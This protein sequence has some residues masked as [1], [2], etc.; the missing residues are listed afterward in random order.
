MTSAANRSCQTSREPARGAEPNLR[1]VW[2]PGGDRH[3]RT[4]A[5]GRTRADG[6]ARDSGCKPIVAP[7]R[8]TPTAT[9]VRPVPG[10]TGLRAT[11]RS[12][13]RQR[14]RHY[15]ARPRH[16]VGLRNRL[17][18]GCDLRVRREE[19]DP[20][21]WWASERRRLGHRRHSARLHRRGGID[22]V[23]RP[24]RH[25]RQHGRQL[26]QSGSGRIRTPTP[27]AVSRTSAARAT[28]APPATSATPEPRAASSPQ[29][30]QGT[31]RLPPVAV[32]GRRPAQRRTEPHPLASTRRWC[33][34][35]AS[36]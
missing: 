29:G 15:V 33:C 5:E 28:P 25:S 24:V 35:E 6:H 10:R 23:D 4:R 27:S 31:A 32:R 17:H 36:T 22:L 12:V 18:P 34:V 16:R 14:A 20:S 2:D 3:G 8:T 13:V 26:P 7:R 1:Q 30:R 11:A 19:P 21:Q 9:G